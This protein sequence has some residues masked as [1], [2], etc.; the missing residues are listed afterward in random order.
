MRS[1]ALPRVGRSHYHK[2]NPDAQKIELPAMASGK[3]SK[4]NVKKKL[5]RARMEAGNQIF[6]R[7]Y[8]DFPLLP[9][10]A[11]H[12][13][14]PINSRPHLL[15]L[16]VTPCPLSIAASEAYSTLLSPHIVS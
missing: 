6:S 11:C 1:A 3:E 9:P 12:M 7:I 14:V 16:T 13:P 10:P 4:G 2:E 5:G 8:F 15:P